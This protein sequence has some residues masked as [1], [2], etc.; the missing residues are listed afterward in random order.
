MLILSSFYFLCEDCDV[1]EKKYVGICKHC[2]PMTHILDVEVPIGTPDR[3]RKTAPNDWITIQMSTIH[4]EGA[5]AL[6]DIPVG[7]V[8]GPYGG[9]RSKDVTLSGYEW[10]FNDHTAVDGWCLSTA[11]WM[12][13]VNCARNSLEQNVVAF[14]NKGGLYY[15]IVR[16]IE[17][18]QELLVFYGRSYAKL[19]GIDNSSYFKSPEKV[20]RTLFKCEP[21]Y[22][23]FYIKDMYLRH[24]R[25]CP[26]K[27][28]YV[29]VKVAGKS[30]YDTSPH[31]L[32]Q[33][34]YNFFPY[35]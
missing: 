18:G 31:F 8:F 7:V 29:N 23:G 33:I 13:Y 10:T 22:F 9:I 30:K 6:R 34:L 19:L 15:R 2:G 24:S 12:R 28:K 3:A 26:N 5:F 17:T 16:P 35:S 27:F 25:R 1:C 14:Q 11:N 32:W 20:V 4:G 21:C